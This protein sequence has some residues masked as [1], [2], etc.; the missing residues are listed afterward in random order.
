[1]HY[2]LGCTMLSNAINNGTFAVVV[3]ILELYY[4][5]VPNDLKFLRIYNFPIFLILWQRN[6]CHALFQ[7][8]AQSNH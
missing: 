6:K 3:C 5:K 4:A 2:V 1:M 8:F 7:E